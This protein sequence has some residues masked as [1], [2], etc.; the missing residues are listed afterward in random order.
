MAV[1]RFKVALNN[2]RYPLLST[3]AQRSVFV[4]GLDAAPRTPRIFMGGDESADYN[5]AQVVY[6]ENVMPTAEGVHSVGYSQIIAPT[7]NTDFDQIFALRDSDENVVLFSPA[8]GQNYVYD[9]VMEQWAADDIE[10]IYGLTL[11]PACD[12]AL[13]KVSYAYV[14]GKTFICYSRL[15]SDDSPAADM[16]LLYWDGTALQ[17][18]GVLITNLPFPAGEIDCIGSSNGY[19]IIASG[20]SVAW[21]P[22]NGAAFDFQIF[23][24]GAFTGAGVQVPEEIQGNVRAVVSVSGGFLIFTVR[25]CIGASYNAQNIASP[26]IFKEVADAGGLES[27][28][29]ATVEGTLGRVYAYTTAGLQSIS[30]NSAEFILPEIADFIAGR[31][32]ERYRFELHELYQGRTSLDFYV[33]LTTI[34]NRYLVVSYGTYPGIYSF[35]IVHDFA[36]KRN[37]KLRMVHRDCFYYNYGVIEKDLTYSMLGDVPYDDP[38]LTTYED[39][40]EQSNAFVSAQ[41]G[42]AFLKST[43][44]VVVANWSDEARDAPDAAVVV[45]G[46]VQLTRA[47]NVQFNRLEAE[48][49]V[50]AIAVIQPSYDGRN[51][52]PAEQLVDCGSVGTFGYYGGMYDCKNFNIAI[53]GTFELSTLILEGTTSG[54]F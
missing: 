52:A 17:D 5:M 21:A 28:E 29:Q 4:P 54:R 47:A 11:D 34:A 35:A 16:S 27:Y 31:Q 43:G 49:M 32:I 24:N 40:T 23:A 1:Q 46:R 3:K 2:A 14:D 10:T 22:F 33:K 37:G 13:S 9:D 19:L 41:H 45:I 48:G 36:L 51:L 18:P 12:P 44:E 26:W 7:V 53:E 6:C 30:L 15:K 38:D 20:I 39:T 50:N 8:A 42:L 25:N